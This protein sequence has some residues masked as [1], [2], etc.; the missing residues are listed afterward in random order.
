MAVLARIANFYYIILV[1][2]ELVSSPTALRLSDH[3]QFPLLAWSVIIANTLE[4]V[5]FIPSTAL[6]LYHISTQLN[7]DGRKVIASLFMDHHGLDYILLIGTKL[8]ILIGGFFVLS[9]GGQDNATGAINYVVT[10][11]HTYA[12]AT[13]MCASFKTT[14]AILNSN[15]NAHSLKL[16][17]STT[18][19]T[20]KP[21][22]R[23]ASETRSVRRMS[24]S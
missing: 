11:S 24:I 15:E 9:M 20:S 23:P 4:S 1:P 7:L 17:F 16:P 3:P 21:S 12:I 14:R 5:C 10:W 2:S 6:F 18:G 8:Y 13:F 19:N 22:S